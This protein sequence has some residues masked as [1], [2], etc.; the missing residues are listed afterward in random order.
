MR[1]D[2]PE[3]QRIFHT[4]SSMLLNPVSV[5]ESWKS[6]P[7][8]WTASWDSRKGS[9]VLKGKRNQTLSRK[10]TRKKRREGADEE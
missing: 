8:T 4:V 7:A 10:A 9:S 3:F 2:E 5:Q 6:D 1:N